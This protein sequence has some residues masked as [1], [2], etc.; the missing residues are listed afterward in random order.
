MPELP[1][2]SSIATESKASGSPCARASFILCIGRLCL[3]ANAATTSRNDLRAHCNKHSLSGKVRQL[4]KLQI[5]SSHQVISV[6][7]VS[8]GYTSSVA[9]TI[10]CT[11]RA[12]RDRH[13]TLLLLCEIETT[14]Y[15]CCERSRRHATLAVR[16]RDNTLLL[17]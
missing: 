15:S 1:A 8:Q 10:R 2:A 7:T 9:Q 4:G 3:S 11:A 5:M 12:V 6:L 16:G 17:L 14:R 13:N